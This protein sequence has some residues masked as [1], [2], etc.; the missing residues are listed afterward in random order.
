MQDLR[1]N[2]KLPLDQRQ[3]KDGSANEASARGSL[4]PTYSIGRATHFDL[5]TGGRCSDNSNPL[6][7]TKE[8]GLFGSFGSLQDC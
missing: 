2:T 6:V 5:V 4:A 8:R 7:D 1:L 3:R